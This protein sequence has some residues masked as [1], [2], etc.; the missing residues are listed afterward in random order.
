MHTR[1]NFFLDD[2]CFVAHS[3]G[4]LVDILEQILQS[5]NQ[6]VHNPNVFLR[7]LFESLFQQ[8]PLIKSENIPS[9]EEKFSRLVNKIVFEKERKKF[10]KT[11]TKKFSRLLK[12]LIVLTNK[13]CN[14]FFVI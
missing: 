1:N 4:D 13:F 3:G 2:S 6:F 5:L 9:I 11:L 10:E 12:I 8:E 14:H 7:P